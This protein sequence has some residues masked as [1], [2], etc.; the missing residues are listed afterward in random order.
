M[1]ITLYSTYLLKA[2]DKR[3]HCDISV[4][5]YNNVFH[6]FSMFS[7]HQEPLAKVCG[8]CYKHTVI[9]INYDASRC[10][11]WKIVPVVVIY[12]CR[13]YTKIGHKSANE[14]IFI[15]TLQWKND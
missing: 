15:V 4:K 1:N 7:T 11:D 3:S 6:N 2:N 12:D 13:A 10:A 9:I 8:H 5:S 14:S